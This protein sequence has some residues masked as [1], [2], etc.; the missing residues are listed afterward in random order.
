[1]LPPPQPGK[2]ININLR[3]GKVCYTPPKTKKCIPLTEPVQIPVGSVIDTTKGEI[4]LVSAADK[5][6]AVQ[7]AW[8]YSGIFKVG[9]LSDQTTE[10]TLAGPKLSCPKGKKASS[11]GQEAEDPQA[12][13]QR[14]GQ[15]P[16]QGQLQLGDGA[17]H[18]LGRHRP[19][20]RHAHPGQGGLASSSATSRSART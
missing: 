20:R 19:L 12:V 8:F 17:R 9:Q 6:G 16:H 13:G 5:G 18:A 7:N 11:L 14:Q 1:M 2:S 3:K 15:V 10:L 4:N